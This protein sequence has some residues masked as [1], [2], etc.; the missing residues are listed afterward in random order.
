MVTIAVVGD[1]PPEHSHR[2]ATVDA[3]AH[4]GASAGVA[5]EPWW[6]GTES[7]S[8]GAAG[9]LA[10]ADGVLVA[11]GSPY[12]SMAGALAAIELARVEGRPLLGT[13]GGFQHVVIEYARHALGYRD[14][15]HAEYEPYA[16][17]LFVTPL[18]C[19]LAGRAMPVTLRRGTVAAAAYGC[20]AATER[21]S[22]NFGLDPARRAL[23]EQGGLVVSGVDAEG[24][25]RVLEL[26]GHP[27]YVA[28]LF[29]PQARST[30]AQ[31]HP[32]VV[33][34]VAA[35]ATARATAA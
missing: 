27:F 23:L 35:A 29:V 11:P 9:A 21:Y 13:C 14:A 15:Q 18:S 17:T 26:P 28:T 34:L 1:L 8:A 32:L 19:S 33:A 3:L 7:L 6:V 16:S 4:A 5:V 20:P 25:V 22:C 24:E 31:P 12:R 10:G 2:R 30:P